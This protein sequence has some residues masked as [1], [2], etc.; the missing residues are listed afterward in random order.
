MK[1]GYLMQADAVDMSKVSG[2]QLHVEAIVQ[3]LKKR[4]HLVRMVASHNGQIV[5]SDDLVQW[6]PAV[7]G[8]SD[9]RT[10]RIFESVLRGLQNRLGLPFLRL[11]DS[12]RFSDACVSALI[13]YDVLYE[14]Y[15][16]ISYGG[17]IAAKR[18]GIPCV[19]E[20]NGDLIEEYHQLGIHLSNAQWA[21]IKFITKLM[22]R[23]VDHIVAVGETIKNRYVC[24]WQLDNSHISVVTNGFDVEH[25]IK[26]KKQEDIRSR[27]LINN[28]HVVIYVGSFQPW[29]GV[30]LI[31]EAFSQ[32][33]ITKTETNLILVGNG[34]L[35]S[36]I[37]KR[38]KA[39]SL[40]NS[41]YFT[42][43]VPH[44][45]VASLLNIADVAV[46][47]HRNS[48]AEIVETPL[49]LFEYMAA[50]KAIVAPSVKNMERVLTHRV[51]GLL[52]PPD[53]PRALAISI[54]E[55]LED[56][57]LRTALGQ[58]AR[59]QALQKHSWDRAAFEIETILN[60]LIPKKRS[61]KRSYD[62]NPFHG[63][64]S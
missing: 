37:E 15:G 53:D 55:L 29:H 35:R 12:Y 8:F 13:G 48:A 2:P 7:L 22:M 6:K 38:V 34:P 33:L 25:F 63:A 51:T 3:R 14:R 52:V 64:N 10:F 9:I 23:Q 57:Q 5:W 49:K 58:A 59:E 40:E 4:G 41:V 27:Y 17:L 36:E 39:L 62:D 60:E 42:G 32:L 24:R 54:N 21:V 44:S 61:V 1:I 47:Y 19:Y 45:D 28:G 50:G 20:I 30:D 46:I 18:L 56:S 11:F 31:L 26:S 43:T 16:M